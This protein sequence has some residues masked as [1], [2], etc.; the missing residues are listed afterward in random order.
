M[1]YKVLER[2]VQKKCVSECELDKR[3]QW[4]FVDIG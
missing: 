2:N 3:G 4:I 1:D